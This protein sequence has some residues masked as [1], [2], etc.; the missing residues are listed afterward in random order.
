MSPFV[1]RLRLLLP[2]IAIHVLVAFNV[3]ALPGEAAAQEWS[4][5]R[6]KS[7]ISFALVADGQ[8]IEGRFEQYKAD[9][10]LDPEDPTYGEVEASINLASANTGQPQVDAILTGPEWLNAGAY[11]TARFQSSSIREAGDGRYQMTG[12]LTLRGITKP[13]TMPLTVEQSGADGHMVAELSINRRAFNL[14]PATGGSP[15][16]DDL[17]ILIELTGK[18]LDN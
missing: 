13:V 14:G 5:N 9:I 16:G 3:S 7:R 8:P 12:T 2:C 11:P 17:R 6:A 10:R 1:L 4:V 18:N 15:G